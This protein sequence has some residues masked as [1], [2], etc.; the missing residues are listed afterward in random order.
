MI[1]LLVVGGAVT[2]LLGAVL[3]PLPGPGVPLLG[4]G[5]FALAAGTL[6]HLMA[7]QGT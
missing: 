4:I 3:I 1:R 6:H 7:R 2:A 5:A